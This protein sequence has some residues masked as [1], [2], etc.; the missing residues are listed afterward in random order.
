MRSVTWPTSCCLTGQLQLCL[1]CSTIRHLTGL[2][3]VALPRV[4][5]A[6]LPVSALP[7]VLDEGF[8]ISLVVGLP[9]NSIFCPFWLFYVF[10]LLSFFWLCEEAQCVYLRLHLGQK[11]NI[12]RI[13]SQP[14]RPGSCGML[15]MKVSQE[16]FLCQDFHSTFIL[17][18]L[19]YLEPCP[20]MWDVASQCNNTNCQSGGGEKGTLA[21][22]PRSALY[23]VLATWNVMSHH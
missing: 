14:S 6:R 5:S 10:K 18:F 16:C 1:P 20:V 8:F 2:A 11:S 17:L 19:L 3:A 15:L 9:Y 7:M 4:L 23:S 13:K 12:L 21:L 22:S